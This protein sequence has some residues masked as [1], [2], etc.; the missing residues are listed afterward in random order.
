MSAGA[1]RLFAWLQ[2][3]AF[4]REMHLTAAELLPGGDRRAWLDVGCGPGVLTRIAA[5]RGYAARG[6]D[7]DSDMIEAAV[8]LAAERRNPAKFAV[9]NIEAER[10]DEARYDV[11]SASSLLVVV[12]DP[13]TTLRQLVSLAKPN[14]Q[15]LII[16]ASRELTRERAFAEVL[17]RG[18]A[19]RAYMLQVWA[20]FRSGRTLAH[21]TFDQPGLTARRHSILNGLVD[22][23][24]V[25]S[26]P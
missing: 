10:A 19:D 12:A 17:A 1:A 2:D 25:G 3:A 26:A 13:A 11:V 14:G 4:Y 23:W 22:A 6:V 18:V 9:S 20:L 7:H 5:E 21:S 16:E 8:R 15:A 24:I